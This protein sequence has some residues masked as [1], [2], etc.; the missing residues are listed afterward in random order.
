VSSCAAI[1]VLTSASSGVSGRRISSRSTGTSR[2]YFL[3][4]RD[5]F[6]PVAWIT[7]TALSVKSEA[8]IKQKKESPCLIRRAL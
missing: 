8:L 2:P 7:P 1:I 4:S 3:A 5:S 6:R